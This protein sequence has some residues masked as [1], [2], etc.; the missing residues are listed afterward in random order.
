MYKLTDASITRE[1]R[2]QELKTLTLSMVREIT[3]ESVI[4]IAA[5]C[6]SL[7]GL[8]LNHCA[9]LTDQGMIAAACH[10]KRLTNL[11]ISCCDKITNQALEV[12]MQQCKWLRSLDVSMCGGLLIADIERL[13]HFHPRLTSVKAKYMGVWTCVPDSLNETG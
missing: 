5:H 13:Q 8:A 12:L 2:F 4:S 3:D 10:M 6:R 11:E 7:E 9:H 1:I